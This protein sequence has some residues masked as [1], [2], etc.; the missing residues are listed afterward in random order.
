MV[1]PLE[2]ITRIFTL[3]PVMVVVVMDFVTLPEINI[4]SPMPYEGWSVVILSGED[5]AAW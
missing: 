5:G 2:F 3:T 4:V 1:E